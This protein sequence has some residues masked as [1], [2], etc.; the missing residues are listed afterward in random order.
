MPN[1][2]RC[3]AASTV[4]AI[5][6]PRPILLLLLLLLLL[7]C[8]RTM[9]AIRARHAPL[10]PTPVLPVSSLLVC[11]HRPPLRTT[12]SAPLVM[13]WDTAFLMPRALP[14]AMASPS[15]H[16]RGGSG[17]AVVAVHACGVL[18]ATCQRLVHVV[19]F[20]LRRSGAAPGGW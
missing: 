4:V 11:H 14:Y 2:L 3:L 17:V 15:S 7:L 12:W 13:L 8:T 19:G 16:A 5:V 20:M 18:D 10:T 1:A 9:A 6:H